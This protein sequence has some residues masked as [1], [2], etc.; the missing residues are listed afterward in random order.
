M[1]LYW[2]FEY[3]TDF[4][5]KTRYFYGTETAAQRRIKR[6]TSDRKD[7]KNISKSRVEFLK[8]E[9]KAYFIDL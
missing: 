6:Y 4:G 7:L 3:V 5:S 1:K 9:K 8:T 2:Q